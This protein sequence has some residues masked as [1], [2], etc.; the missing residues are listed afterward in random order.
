MIP[1][2]L[3]RRASKCDGEETTLA[4]LQRETAAHWACQVINNQTNPHLFA[5]G[6]SS[7]SLLLYWIV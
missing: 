2:L 7:D 4:A 1:A 5:I 3:H 6:W